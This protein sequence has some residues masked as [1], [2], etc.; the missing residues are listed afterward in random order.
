MRIAVSPTRMEF[1]R[2]QKRLAI[3]VR[4]HKLLKDKLEGL[5]QEFLPIVEEYR[6]MRL[7]VD[8]ELPGVMRMFVLA[9]IASDRHTIESAL[10]QSQATLKLSSEQKRIMSV[11]VPSLSVEFGREGAGY[12]FLDTPA[13]LDSA[14]S[15]LR[16]YFPKLVRLAELE[17]MVWLL[18]IEIEKT[19]RRVN[20]LEYVMIPQIRES[21]RYIRSK[22]EEL[23]RSTITRLMKVKEIIA[24]GKK[25]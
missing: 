17:Q 5:I 13:E 16:E 23:E 10:I 15:D 3:A 21:L 14:I 22:L 4:G 12:S 6:K 8:R 2:L 18:S 11:P 19:R 1:L 7:E 24:S 25:A 20:A 9:R